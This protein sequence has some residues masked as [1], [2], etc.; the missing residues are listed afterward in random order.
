M[1]ELLLLH[2]TNHFGNP[3]SMYQGGCRMKEKKKTA[4]NR[5]GKSGPKKGNPP[6]TVG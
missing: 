6:K 3:G 4:C 1:T 2:R 5:D